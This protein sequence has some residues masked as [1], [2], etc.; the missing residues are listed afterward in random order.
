MARGWESKAV[1]EQIDSVEAD[2]DLPMNEP[3][4]GDRLDLE[5]KRQG[6]LLSRTKVLRDLDT[7]C[8]PRYRDILVAA[9]ADLEMQLERFEAAIG[10]LR[11]AD[12]DEGQ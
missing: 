11:T 10:G 7:C 12:G 5:R 3:I 2:R 6:V 1:E 9:L 4:P 8:N